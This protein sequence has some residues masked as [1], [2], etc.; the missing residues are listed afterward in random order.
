PEQRI[1]ELPL[2]P[3]WE[4]QKLLV[5]WNQ[6]QRE[7]PH[8]CIHQLFVEQVERTPNAVAVVFGNQQ[9]TYQELNSRANQLAHYL[10]ELGVKPDNLIGICI[11]R[12]LDIFVGILGIL[13]A[14]GAYLPLDPDYPQERLDYMFR[15]SQVS[16]L[17]TTK[18]L[19]TQIPE[20]YLQVVYLDADWDVIATKSQHNRVSEVKPENLA[21]LIYTSGST[22]RPKGVMVRHCSLV[23]AYLGWEQAY[24][25]RTITTSHLQMANFSFDVF[26]G[27]LVRALCSGAKLVVCPREW[28][29]APELLYNLMREQKVDC[30]E[31]VPPVIRNL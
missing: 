15:D 21:Y 14:G 29:L 22:G 28:L 31:F 24:Q 4:H 16:M 23:N 10:Q 19:V 1:A 3:P 13:K 5:E 30:A 11:E 6:T 26:T 17:L 9:L 20:H 7:Y 8:K 18:K 25:L 27:D 12:S 2:L